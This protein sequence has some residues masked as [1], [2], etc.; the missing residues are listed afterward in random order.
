LQRGHRLYSRIILVDAPV[1]STKT[2]LCVAIRPASPPLLETVS[3]ALSQLER[4]SMIEICTAR[5]I[6]FKNLAAL[7]ALN[8]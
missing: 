7:R 5:Q 6:H 3:R 2:R 8:A 4:D 1:S